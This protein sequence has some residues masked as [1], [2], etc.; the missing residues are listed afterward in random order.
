MSAI[1]HNVGMFEKDQPDEYDIDDSR[2]ISELY[3]ITVDD[4]HDHRTDEE[5]AEDA[6][7]KEKIKDLRKNNKLTNESFSA[8]SSNDVQVTAIET[9]VNTDGKISVDNVKAVKDQGDEYDES[10]KELKAF[11][12]KCAV[13]R[14]QRQKEEEAERLARPKKSQSQIK[15]ELAQ[16]VAT[17]ILMKESPLLSSLLHQY[18]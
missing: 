14:E 16:A 10:R 2:T 1:D 8:K 12:E 15:D 4:R 6:E 18:K 9:S 13:E 7:M 11:E 5:K 17:N 3:N